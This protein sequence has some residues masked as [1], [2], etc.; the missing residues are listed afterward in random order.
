MF[1][2]QGGISSAAQRNATTAGDIGAGYGAD[3]GVVN[4]NLLPFLTR[5]LN[6]PTGYTQAQRGNMLTAAEAGSGGSNAGLNT[7]AALA[8]ARS[9][10]PGSISG[11]LAEAARQKDK[12]NAS[13]A[14][15]I[16]ANNANVQQQQQQSAAEGL[17]RMYGQDTDAQLK[18]MG[19]QNE[20]LNTA[21]STYGTGSWL[22]GLNQIAGTG[23]KL[24]AMG[25][26]FG[27]PG[28]QGFSGLLKG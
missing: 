10:N 19:L 20:D 1:G 8:T 2:L 6:N 15:G 18:A 16:E 21:A 27:I 23:L 22:Q 3:A 25:A 7:E 12:A 24:G 28:M 26:G 5:Q 11:G 13:T 17:G 4:A 14:E 9:R